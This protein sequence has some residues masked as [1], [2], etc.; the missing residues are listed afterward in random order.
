MSNP[1]GQP[2]YPPQQPPQQR[3]PYPPPGAFHQPPPPAPPMWQS[4]PPPMPRPPISGTANAALTIAVLSIPASL[5]PLLWI[6][7]AAVAGGGLWIVFVMIAAFVALPL[8]LGYR[9]LLEIKQGRAHPISRQRAVLAMGISGVYILLA[10]GI[11]LT[12]L[13]GG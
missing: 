7:A 1:Y 3:P 6:P 13:T 2:P 10:A 5:C 4:P 11:G 12:A 9:A 8:I